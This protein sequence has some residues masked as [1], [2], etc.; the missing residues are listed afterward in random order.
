MKKL[1]VF[2]L[3]LV[4]VA[5]LVACGGGGSSSTPPAS[6]PASASTPASSTGGDEPAGGGAISKIAMLLPGVIT[7]QSWC[8]A[9][10]EGLMELDA[11]GYETAFTE[12]LEVVNIE[13]AFRNYAQEG[14][15]LI[16]GHGSQFGD[17]GVRVAEE[18]PETYF[19]IFGKPPSDDYPPNM[20]F[21]DSKT[22]EGSYMAGAL[23]ALMSESGKIGYLGGIESAGQ[24]S[25]KNAY[26]QGAKDVNP[27]IEILSVMVGTFDDPAKGKE[28][29]LAQI[30]Q[31]VDVIMQCADS[32]GL[33]AIEAA[34]E[35]GVYIIGYGSDQ[36]DLAPELMLSSL[37]EVIPPVIVKQA[38]LVESGEF[39]GIYRP[40]LAGDMIQLAPYGSA[41]PKEVQDE[42]AAIKAKI[43]SGEIVVVESFD[44]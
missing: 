9:A 38:Q 39:G 25:M 33:G 7:D 10:Y 37:V 17:A 16:I 23:A 20:G 26:I 22:Y 3:S 44:K 12:S 21:V 14:Y 28:S 27:D 43:V 24:L 35:K 8:T 6:Q 1:L 34:K 2:L 13:A 42:L 36:N 15:E 11:Q 30:E 29:A 19:F 32:T 4:M 40:D 41:V 31:G 18:F 5:S